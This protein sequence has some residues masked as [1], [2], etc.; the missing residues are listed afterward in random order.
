[1]VPYQ[2]CP[3]P[4]MT[5][6]L[7]VQSRQ[8]IQVVTIDG[9]QLSAARAILFVLGEIGYYPRI[10]RLATRRPFIWPIELFYWIVARNRSF[11][12]RFLFRRE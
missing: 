5:P 6:R 9:H 10:A 2:D 4:P 11:F 12:D 7:R 8:A 3:Y 1:M